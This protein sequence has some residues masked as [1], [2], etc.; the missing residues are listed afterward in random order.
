MVLEESPIFHENPID[1]MTRKD[2][3][4]STN[5]SL[6][7]SKEHTQM[8]PDYTHNKVKNASNHSVLNIKKAES[9]QR[10]LQDAGMFNIKAQLDSP[11][12]SNIYQNQPGALFDSNLVY[13]KHL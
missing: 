10:M 5:T 3:K 6:V 11:I 4:S 9:L 2:K 7:Q 13:F 1:K 12:P 8:S